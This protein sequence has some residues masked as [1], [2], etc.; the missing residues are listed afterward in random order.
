MSLTAWARTPLMQT[1]QRYAVVG[2]T[3]T[4]VDWALFALLLYGLDW[5]YLLAATLSFMV[6]T[7]VNYLLS[8][9]WVFR[10]GRHARHLEITLIYLVS[11]IGLL[12]N[13]A[14]LYL[15]VEW[16]AMH[17]FLAKVLAS[18]SAFLW[19]FSAR[20]LWVFERGTGRERVA[21]EPVK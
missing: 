15:L 4:L 12:V 11:A 13:L 17:V 18:L 5:Q 21:T 9:F 2:C 7:L 20:Y 10:G 16:A 14:V 8:L 3:G 6:A 1:M 19:N